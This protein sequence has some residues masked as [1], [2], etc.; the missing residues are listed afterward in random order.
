MEININS[1]TPIPQTPAK[2]PSELCLSTDTDSGH[3]NALPS[4]PP[5]A[6]TESKPGVLQNVPHSGFSCFLEI[7]IAVKRCWPHHHLGDVVPSTALYLE[8]CDVCIP[9]PAL[10]I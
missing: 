5:V 7:R 2:C 8:A 3:N 10:T 9:P 1:K 4:S 6:N